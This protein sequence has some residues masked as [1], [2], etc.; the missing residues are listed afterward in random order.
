MEIL[1][2]KK[3]EYE[4]VTGKIACIRNGWEVHKRKLNSLFLREKN[5]LIIRGRGSCYVI[6]KRHG[7]RSE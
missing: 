4:K 2:Y 6:L 5:L 1:I 7:K 3:K